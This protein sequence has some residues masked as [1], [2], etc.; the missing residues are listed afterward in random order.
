MAGRLGRL[1]RKS[2]ETGKCAQRD[3]K[4]ATSPVNPAS[5]VN[6]FTYY[7]GRGVVHYSTLLTEQA[8]G[9]FE[10]YFRNSLMIGN[11]KK[12]IVITDLGGTLLDPVTCSLR[13]ALPALRP[14]K[15]LQ[16]PCHMFKQNQGRNRR[17]GALFIP[18]YKEY[19][20]SY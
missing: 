2:Q 3:D 10:Q 17:S 15:E 8:N 5:S 18:H 7:L 9:T 11:M 12:I 19:K 20:W 14:I 4:G 6:F 13:G 1:W 16:V